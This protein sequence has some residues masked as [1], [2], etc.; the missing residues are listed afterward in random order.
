MPLWKTTSEATTQEEVPEQPG[1]LKQIAEK[2]KNLLSFL[3]KALKFL[4]H[5]AI[6]LVIVILLG[7]FLGMERP[8]N[9][10]NVTRDGIAAEDRD[11][12]ITE[13]DYRLWDNMTAMVSAMR[14][15]QVEL[16]GAAA[17]T[18]G[19]GIFPQNEGIRLKRILFDTNENT[20]RLV[21]EAA[22]NKEIQLRVE[23]GSLEKVLTRREGFSEGD[24]ILSYIRW[25]GWGK[26]FHG[27]PRYICRVQMNPNGMPAGRQTVEEQMIRVAPFGR[28]P[29]FFTRL[30]RLL[31]E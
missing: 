13:A 31:A 3:W 10:E 23:S 19:Q 1:I 7:T 15:E 27:Y 17:E 26:F 29:W 4:F 18:F 24:S 14:Y 11:G 12:V 6:V 9:I 25:Y 21:Y 5:L 16:E 8:Q 30:R 22:V 28:I 2:I 20:V